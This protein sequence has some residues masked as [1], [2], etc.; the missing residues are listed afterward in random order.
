MGNA[1]VEPLYQVKLLYIRQ[2]HPAVSKKLKSPFGSKLLRRKDLYGASRFIPDYRPQ[3]LGSKIMAHSWTGS[4]NQ[5]RFEKYNHRNQW[6]PIEVSEAPTSQEYPLHLP[7]INL[8]STGINKS[9]CHTV[10]VLD[11][12][13]SHRLNAF[14]YF[15]DL[16]LSLHPENIY[17][18]KHRVQKLPSVEYD[19]PKSHQDLRIPRKLN[20]FQSFIPRSITCSK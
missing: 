19:E 12:A 17:E 16:L 15:R 2:G 6:K 14:Q 20:L 9:E 13:S 3:N 7:P 11:L 1:V 5:I 10:C 8:F 18:I 4:T